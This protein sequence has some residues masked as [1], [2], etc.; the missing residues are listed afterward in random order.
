MA[1]S[2]KN[3][4][5]YF[6]AV[7]SRPDFPGM[8]RD[9]LAKWEKTGVIKKYLEKNSKRRERFSFL[10]GPITA[11]NPMGVHHAWG[12]TYKDLFQ[13][14]KNMQGFAERFQNG[15]D[16]QG[17]WVEVEVEKELN[18]KSKKD[19]ENIV[20]GNPKAS[21]AKFIELCRERVLKFSKIQT[22]QSKRL[23]YFMDWE[24]SYYTMSDENNYLIWYFLAKCHVQGLI[25]KGLDTVPWCPRCGTAI[26][27]HE[28]LTE[29]YQ[30]ITH[31]A[32]TVKYP[33]VGRPGEFLLVWTTTPW[34]LPS[35][36]AIAVNPEL[37]YSR[38]RLGKHAHLE[39]VHKQQ[40][41]AHLRGGETD[42][43]YY[44]A[45]DRI[46][47]VLGS[48]VE[49][50]EEITGDRLLN[51][52]YSGP[53]DNL[54]A[55][56]EARKSNP[57]TFHRTIDGGG[58]VTSE[59]GTGLVHIAPACGHE[60]FQLGKENN[61]TLIHVIDEQAV[62]LPGFGEFSGKKAS[63]PV[64]IIDYLKTGGF[65]LKEEQYNHRYPLCWRCRS[66]LFFRAVSE[67]YIKMD[68][69]RGKI[70][71]VAK[72]INWLPSW[73]LD[74]ELD[75]LKNMSDWLISKKRYWGLALPIWE[76]QE[77]GWFTVISGHDELKEKAVE[78]WSEFS[79]HSPHKPWVDEVK[80][81]CEKC[82]STASRI[83][84]VGNPW[85]DA[86][87]VPFSTLPKEWFPA[88]FITESFPGQ[89]KNW[90]YSLLCMATI[91]ENTEPFRTVLGFATLLGGD[92]RPM[93][94]SW[95]NA[96]EFGEG[97]DKI[98]VDVM[99]WMY[100]KQNPTNNLIFGYEVADQ[101][102]RSFHLTLW[103]V[104]NFFVTYATFDGWQPR[105]SQATDLRGVDSNNVLDKWIIARL[106]QT[107][108]TTTESLDKFDAHT[109]VLAIEKFVEDL[110]TW[111]IRRS[112]ERV[113]PGAKDGKDKEE[114]Y[115]TTYFVLVI[116]AKMLAPFLPFM[117]ELMFI[118]LTKG[119]SVHLEDWPQL[120]ELNVREE[121]LVE[122]ME[123]IRAAAAAGHAARKESGIKVR[124][125]LKKALVGAPVVVPPRSMLVLL[126]DELNVKEVSW[127]KKR[128]KEVE[129]A[130][131]TRITHDL[132]E[133]GGARELVR[134]IQDERKKLGLRITDTV[135]VVAPWI[136]ANKKLGFWVKQKTLAGTL[137]KGESLKV[138]EIKS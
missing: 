49:V 18:L 38:V 125:P 61:L 30:E 137:E 41:L 58:L 92:G 116:L 12:R 130:L 110:S 73:G 91:L 105:R 111:Y 67:W 72:K 90:F 23:G 88:D 56:E 21:I 134:Q 15:F 78:G 35:N 68:P 31:T 112:R 62:F 133:E 17:L 20:P 85:L 64:P 75:W 94:K 115:E 77:C 117:S 114:F 121:A 55:V 131:T 126:E 107:L 13:R 2:K 81:R 129:L 24:N 83:P 99:R 50:L 118:N 6:G 47:P 40:H 51:I 95:G 84:D 70:A 86:G 87:I 45:R 100:A 16:C 44:I 37:V 53:F 19:I 11:N 98:G 104:Y 32:V 89:F 69:V 93:H 8:E 79:K 10:D 43:I 71:E 106:S 5:N 120:P 59:E 48:D 33:I 124:Q 29:E 97:A 74:R 63:D 80:I 46:I 119:E 34:T 28:I 132:V 65:L 101:T 109:G 60:D 22:E 136:P 122:M 54:P 103:N 9:L 14:Y 25:Y 3:Q 4:E 128:V 76:C 135:N 138:E 96:I 42:E 7:N 82:S 26:S 123:M 57:R 36:V 127:K 102:R 108:K 66:E 27:Q 52:E 1:S 113:G 39:G